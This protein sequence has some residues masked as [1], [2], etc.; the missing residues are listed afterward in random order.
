MSWDGGRL[1]ITFNGE[2][3]NFLELRRELEAAATA[4]DRRP[5]PKSSW[6]RTT[7][8]A[9]DCVERLVGMFAFALWDAATPTALAGPR[10]ARQE[11]AVLRDTPA[12]RLRF[13]SELKALSGR[14]PCSRATSTSMRSACI[15]A[16]ATCP[17]PF[18]DLSRRTQAAAGALSD[19]ARAAACP[20]RRYWDP[21]PFAHG[22]TRSGPMHDAEARARSATGDR[23]RS[24]G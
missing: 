17:S 2:I 9:L 22:A 24:S 10:S 4:F 12:A 18:T 13:A 15:C 21:A 11:A 3:Y 1:W 20:S 14:R 6:L 8:G 16:T 19:C 7:S 23:R 5:T